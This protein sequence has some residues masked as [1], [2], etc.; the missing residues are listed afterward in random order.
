MELWISLQLYYTLSFIYVKTNLYF[1]S[2]SYCKQPFLWPLLRKKNLYHCVLTYLEV[3]SAS[4]FQNVF[5]K[6]RRVLTLYFFKNGIF[7]EHRHIFWYVPPFK[8]TLLY[9]QK[10]TI[11][12]HQ[13]FQ[14]LSAFPA[15]ISDWNSL[16]LSILLSS[17]ELQ[18]VQIILNKRNRNI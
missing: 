15:I 6:C 16:Q 17:E 18:T 8:N 9:S 14:Q 2:C 3:N 10:G 11:S 1:W 5:N 13:Q 4:S 7:H 12:F